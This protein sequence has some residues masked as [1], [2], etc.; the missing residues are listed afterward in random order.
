MMKKIGICL[1]FLTMTSASLADVYKYVAPDGSVYYT[2]E[3]KKGLP[4][5]RI[6]KTTIR[7]YKSKRVRTSLAAKKKKYSAIIAKAA[8]KYQL[9]E[10]LL[11]AVIQT[12]S[13]Y[14]PAAVSPKGAVGLMQLMPE[15]AKRYGVKNRKDAWQNIEGGARYLKDLLTMFNSNLKL[16]VAS[17]NAGEGAVMK[18]NNKIPPYPETQNYVK[19]VLALYRQ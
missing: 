19:Q 14:N 11:H 16:A 6:I 8:S 2:D 18:Y 13:A 5:K 4:Y 15:T 3:P 9:D 1:L 17:Y 7:K 10:K 12:E